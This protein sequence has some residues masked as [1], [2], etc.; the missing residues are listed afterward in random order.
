MADTP[1]I[2][3]DARQREALREEVA[4]RTSGWGDVG[5]LLRERDSARARDC[6]ERLRHSIELMDMIG[7]SER[8]G[9]R[10]AASEAQ[11]LTRSLGATRGPR[12][13]QLA[14]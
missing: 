2:T 10:R 1:Q 6:L 7:W 13:A 12:S 9:A 5:S 8:P 4:M 11:P 3:L 14:R